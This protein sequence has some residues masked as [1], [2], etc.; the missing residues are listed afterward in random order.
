MSGDADLAI[1]EGVV[2]AIS[3][4]KFISFMETYL[5]QLASPASPKYLC[6][7]SV[8][9]DLA[10]DPAVAGHGD[11]STASSERHGPLREFSSKHFDAFT[12]YKL[13][14]ESKL[15]AS[16]R[17]FGSEWT[18]AKFFGLCEAAMAD[19]DA[20]RG[21]QGSTRDPSAQATVRDLCAALL[22]MLEAASDFQKFCTMMCDLQD[23]LLDDDD[24]EDV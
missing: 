2:D 9:E 20:A 15:K 13:F 22:D 4:D 21:V 7:T 18:D 19:G 17:L 10:D 24:P 14:F 8:A 23:S 11:S 5:A 6:W 12:T 1:F 16:L 3:N